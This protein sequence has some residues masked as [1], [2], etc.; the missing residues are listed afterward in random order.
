VKALAPA[1]ALLLALTAAAAAAE[2]GDPLHVTGAR[3][4]ARAAPGLEAAVTARL[5][6]G[7]ALVEIRRAGE[8][9]RVGIV[10][11]CALAWVRAD[12]VAAR[13]RVPAAAPAGGVTGETKSDGA[14]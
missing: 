2:P 10:G 9:V 1:S 5:A 12:R 11:G 7:Q 4:N 14:E 3:V 6:R 8:W 13:W